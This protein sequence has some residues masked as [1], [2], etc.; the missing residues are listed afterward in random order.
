MPIF[1]R[2]LQSSFSRTFYFQKIE[3][4]WQIRGKSSV[5]YHIHWIRPVQCPPAAQCLLKMYSPQREI[6]SPI[7][8]CSDGPT[9]H[10]AI[11]GI[12]SGSQLFKRFRKF[13]SFVQSHGQPRTFQAL[14]L[15]SIGK[16]KKKFKF[17]NSDF[18][19][20][21]WHCTNNWGNIWSSTS[22]KTVSKQTTGHA[23]LRH[24]SYLWTSWVIYFPSSKWFRI[25][26]QFDAQYSY[27]TK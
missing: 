13:E 25:V 16:K 14:F 18:T 1:L 26:S 7:K 24:T 15:E 21:L 23:S 20:I 2:I 9:D 11:N 3:K 19:N 8:Q 17:L 4:I 5:N 12:C 27:K 10:L 22:T 6:T